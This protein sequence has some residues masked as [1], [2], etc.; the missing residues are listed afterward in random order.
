MENDW[1]QIGLAFIVWLVI[2]VIFTIIENI[3][4]K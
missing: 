2:L 3:V 4:E 1:K